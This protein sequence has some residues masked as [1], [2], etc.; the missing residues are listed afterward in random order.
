MEKLMISVHKKLKDPLTYVSLF[1][2]I[3][4]ILVVLETNNIGPIKKALIILLIFIT[5][6]LTLWKIYTWY[7]SKR[8]YVF[9]ENWNNAPKYYQVDET[10]KYLAEQK[11]K[12]EIISRTSMQWLLGREIDW[13]QKNEKYINKKNELKDAIKGALKRGSSIHFILQNP[14]LKIGQFGT[15]EQT[16]LYK[17]TIDAIESFEDI[18]K[19]LDQEL[20]ENFTLKISNEIIDNS[21]LRLEKNNKIIRFIFEISIRFKNKQESKFSKPFLAFTVETEEL[22]EFEK[23]FNDIR[24][25]AQPRA[26]FFKNLA[27]KEIDKTIL[28]FNQFSKIRNNNNKYL[29]NPFA[30][31]Y[32]NEL[33]E[34]N[35]SIPSLTSIQLLITN[36]CT[37]HC[38]MC[39]HYKISKKKEAELYFT[40]IQYILKCIKEIG[41]KSII[42]SGGEPLARSDFFEIIEHSSYLGLHTG[43]LTNGIKNE[44]GI[45][46]SI[47]KIDA[48]KIAAYISWIQ[49]SIDSVQNDTYHAI[50]GRDYLDLVL[51]TLIQLIL[52][53]YR[54][55]EITYTIQE[56]NINEI[57]SYRKDFREK[58]S[59]IIDKHFKDEAKDLL[60]KHVLEIPVRFK[61]AHG[62]VDEINY[63]CKEESLKKLLRSFPH[64]SNFNYINSMIDEEFF[65]YKDL[66]SGKPLASRMKSYSKDS[67]CFAMRFS[68]KIDSYGDIYPCC[69]LF[70]DNNSN[71]D[72]RSQYK[73]GSMRS[74]TSNI[75]Y[76]KKNHLKK[77]LLSSQYKKLIN[78]NL[79]IDSE[80][81]TY[82]TRHFYQNEFLNKISAIFDKN[83]ENNLVEDIIENNNYVFDENL[84]I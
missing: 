3:L 43:L 7:S 49:L 25:N 8:K 23:K 77:A 16:R 41:T 59:G 82:C 68:C 19:E 34:S 20:T 69:F 56:R 62:P 57:S 50:R 39:D 76:G 31:L 18:F 30:K 32:K 51:Q 22:I 9:Y 80:A 55:I 12:L 2:L 66:A 81:C 45:H 37:T 46:K 64:Q 27:Y 83:K 4:A 33:I 70:D 73:I 26:E 61:F 36:K 65:N 17:Q 38:I 5:F 53:N 78:T 74:N 60:L 84:W 47:S 6:F 13:N 75:A 1:S 58:I 67:K 79:P 54:N 71:S 35:L 63:L 21:M 52:V 42:I 15:E 11:C 40:E 29:I 14:D 10:L 72:F 48:R 24:T 44:N 28:K